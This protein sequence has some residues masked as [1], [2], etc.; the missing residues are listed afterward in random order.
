MSI[1]LLESRME[2]GKIAEGDDAHT[3]SVRAYLLGDISV[4]VRMLLLKMLWLDVKY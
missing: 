3:Y 2:N 4:P 1:V